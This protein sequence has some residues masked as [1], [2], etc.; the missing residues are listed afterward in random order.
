M[1]LSCST[2]IWLSD[3]GLNLGPLNRGCGALATGPP[4]KSL[5]FFKAEKPKSLEA[6]EPALREQGLWP[7]QCMQGAEAR[8]PGLVEEAILLFNASSDQQGHTLTKRS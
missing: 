3:Q 5:Q 1:C 7:A 2:W 6:P 8:A 4:D